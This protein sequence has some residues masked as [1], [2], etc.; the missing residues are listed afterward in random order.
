MTW[1]NRVQGLGFR[2]E[3]PQPYLTHWIRLVRLRVSGLSL[4]HLGQRDVPL[5]V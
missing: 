2:V 4:G 3:D 5:R 1:L